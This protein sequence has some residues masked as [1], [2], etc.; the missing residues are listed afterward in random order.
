MSTKAA[1]IVA[2]ART[3]IG[4]FGGSLSSLSAVTLGSIA[5]K[6]ALERSGLDGQ[7]ITDVYMGNVV[8]ANLGQAPAK[9]AT[10]GAGLSVKTNCTIINKVCASGLKS[11]ALAA[12]SIQLG[13]SDAIV[14]GG[15]ESMSNIPHYVPSLRWGNKF[16]GAE[17]ID[18]LQ[19]DGLSDAY[20]NSA[21]GVCGD[22]TA[23][24][25]NISR[26]SQDEY[27]IRSYTKSSEST[28]QGKFKTEIAPVSIAQKK[29]DPV[30]I[31]ED[32]EFKKV[33]FG[34]IPGLRPAFTPNGTVTAANASTLND[35]AAAVVV[36][37]EEYLKKYNL[38]PIARIVSYADGEHEPKMFTTAPTISSPIAIQRAGLKISDI[39]YF[40]VNEAFSVVPLAY[41]NILDIDLNKINVNGGAVS[42]GHP[43]GASGTRIAVSLTQILKQNN[44]KY[45]LATICNGGG[46]ST[47][48]ILENVN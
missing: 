4:S 47:T 10:I 11:I 40:E 24:K 37:S 19:K 39:D 33:D 28:S 2:I 31:S 48:M 1:Y 38:S 8:S 12:Q 46:G 18:G 5:I 14:A 23:S 22:E 25:M 30:V 34:K 21:M 45:G 41:S 6:S 9:Q 42:L 43:I 26:E 36:V 35:G 27:A 44:A 3:P 29:G 7:L 13:L 16:G 15:M 17:I 20:D 32:E